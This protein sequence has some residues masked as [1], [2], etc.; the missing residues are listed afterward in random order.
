MVLIP[1]IASAAC[2]NR[3][4][5][6]RESTGRW[7]VTLLTGRLTFQEAQALA[8]DIT[9]KRA[10][11][12]EWVDD[13][14]KTIAKQLGALRVMRPMPS[15]ACEGKTSGVIMVTSFLG[16]KPPAIKMN[17]KFDASTIVVFDEQKE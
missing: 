17:V 3:F 2:V 1:E 5:P 14:G 7:L 8:K 10:E 16:A 6:R 12:L 9:E 15:V 11:P 4:L 13:K